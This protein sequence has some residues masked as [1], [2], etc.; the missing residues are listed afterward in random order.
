[1]DPTRAGIF[2]EYDA[3]ALGQNGI[4]AGRETHA[5]REGS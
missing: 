2:T 4:P 3:Q 5:A 1:M